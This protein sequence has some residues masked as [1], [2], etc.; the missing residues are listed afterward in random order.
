VH[1]YRVCF[2]PTKCNGGPQSPKAQEA[3]CSSSAPLLRSFSCSKFGKSLTSTPVIAYSDMIGLISTLLVLSYPVAHM[4]C[5]FRSEVYNFETASGNWSF[6]ITTENQ[7]NMSSSAGIFMQRHGR[8]DL[9]QLCERYFLRVRGSS[10]YSKIRC[11][12][13]LNVTVLPRGMYYF[14]SS[15]LSF[16]VS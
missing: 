3:K 13:Q 8:S 9:D 16:A 10:E 15:A 6:S 7:M 11:R 5:N 4:R 2:R 12:S 1:P 14:C